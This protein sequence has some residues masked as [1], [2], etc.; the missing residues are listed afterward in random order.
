MPSA[1]GYVGERRLGSGAF[2]EVWLAHQSDLGTPVA[3]KF[4][5]F[6][7]AHLGSEDASAPGASHLGTYYYMARRA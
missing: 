6:G 3:I 4:A 1:P 7:Q 2:G 5:D